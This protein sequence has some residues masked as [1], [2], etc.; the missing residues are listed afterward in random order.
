MKDP[1]VQ[2]LSLSKR[3]L[4]VNSY[5]SMVQDLFSMHLGIGLTIV[6]LLRL[7]KERMMIL[8]YLHK[9]GPWVVGWGWVDI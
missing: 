9:K 2:E 6:Q 4:I 3:Y 8:L 5:Y 7:I 1:A